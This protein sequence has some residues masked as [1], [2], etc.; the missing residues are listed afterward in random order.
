MPNR[1]AESLDF[2]LIIEAVIVTIAYGRYTNHSP[3][4][5]AFSGIQE[6]NPC[7]I[8]KI[9]VRI[10]GEMQCMRKNFHS[11]HKV[12]IGYHSSVIHTT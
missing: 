2:F 4:F 5:A 9:V 1:Y 11:V 10:Y 6:F 3:A 12:A 8:G 7:S